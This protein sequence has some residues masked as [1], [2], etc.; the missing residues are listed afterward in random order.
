MAAQAVRGGAGTGATAEAAGEVEEAGPIPISKLESLGI[1]A[2]VR[3]CRFRGAPVDPGSAARL[4]ATHLAIDS[5]QSPACCPPARSSA[6]R[7][8]AHGGRLPHG[9]V[10]RVRDAQGERSRPRRSAAASEAALRSP[11]HSTSNAT[12]TPPLLP[13]SQSLISIKGISEA[14]GAKL[15]AEAS[16]LV[17]MGFSTATEYHR[18]RGEMLSLTTG[19]KELDKV[20]GGACSLFETAVWGQGGCSGVWWIYPMRLRRA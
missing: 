16:K 4:R 7:Q 3:T 18:V 6:G 12:R 14:K 5:L 13:P 2:S 9:R 15:L 8:E 19:C 10:R 17:D 11:P 20:L 1:P